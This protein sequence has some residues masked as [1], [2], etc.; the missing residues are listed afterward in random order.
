[1]RL[2][3]CPS[4]HAQFDVTELTES[5]IRCHCGAQVDVADPRPVD[6]E[7]RRCPGCGAPVEPQATTC[8]YCGSP[9]VRP[10]DPL[11]LI[12]PECYARNPEG[13]GFCVSCG[14]E[15]RPLPVEPEGEAL[16]CPACEGR[17][18]PRAIGDVRVRECPDCHGLWSESAAFDALVGRAIE[19]RRELPSAG[20]G[21]TG[22]G[23]EPGAGPGDARARDR[24]PGPFT[25]AYR[26]CPVCGGV[27]QRRNYARRSGIIV[28]WCGEHGLWLDADEL[29]AIAAFV[30]GGGLERPREGDGRGDPADPA[31]LAGGGPGEPVPVVARRRPRSQQ[32]AMADAILGLERLKQ[33]ERRRA[34]ARTIDGLTGRRDRAD[35]LSLGDLLSWLVK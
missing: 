26:H 28:D 16:A 9:L 4:C 3:A 17:L 35:G 33:Q 14:V 19:A 1:M 2:V 15:F 11:S 22:G 7:V 29:E 34:L 18:V 23:R 5:R 8:A 24:R 13:A 20:L 31:G 25:V 27:M 10:E 12:C 30:V 6:A 21:A 32:E